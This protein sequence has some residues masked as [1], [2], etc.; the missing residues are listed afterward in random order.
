[1]NADSRLLAIYAGHGAVQTG[2]QTPLLG[3]QWNYWYD[4]STYDC[5]PNQ[6][7]MSLGLN[8]G[9]QAAFLIASS[10]CTMTEFYFY[11]NSQ[12]RQMFGFAGVAHVNSSYLYTFYEN[13]NTLTNTD[14]WM[15]Y[16]RYVGGY[17]NLPTVFTAADTEDNAWA[18]HNWCQ[19]RQGTCLY[20]PAKPLNGYAFSRYTGVTCTGCGLPECP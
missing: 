7:N 9:G 15:E 20:V 6:S 17:Y 10:C 5:F 18:Y 2:G 12:L 11:P 8:A 19:F 4:S 3:F 16:A 14:S 13:T 1:M